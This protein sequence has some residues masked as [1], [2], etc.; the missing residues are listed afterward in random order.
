LFAPVVLDLDGDGVE[1]VSRKKSRASFDYG[2]DGA[3]DDTGWI[4]RDDGFLVID[5]NND[6]LIT[7]ASELSLASEDEDARSGLQGLARLDSNGDGVI[8]S[9]DA[10]FGELRVWQDRNG[11]GRTDAGEL[12]SLEEAGLVAIRLNA[13]TP[14]Q[15]Q[16]KLDRNVIAA[17]TTFVRAN[18]TTSTAADVS[19]AYRP[20]TGNTTSATS[21]ASSFDRFGSDLFLA[22]FRDTGFEREALLPTIDELVG[23]LG[24]ASSQ[25][26]S[27]LF[28]RYA[29]ES[30]VEPA[31]SQ[32][33]L[34]LPPV[35]ERASV[36]SQRAFDPVA[37]SLTMLQDYQQQFLPDVTIELQAND[38]LPIARVNE[39][40]EA[41]PVLDQ[42]VSSIAASE[43]LSAID[44][45]VVEA[46]PDG[47]PVGEVAAQPAT[48][49]LGSSVLLD[50][51]QF[52]V[53]GGPAR[54]AGLPQSPDQSVEVITPTAHVVRPGVDI[55]A[56][57]AQPDGDGTASNAE[58]ARKLAMIRQDMSSFGVAGAGELER[59]RQFEP[60]SSYLYA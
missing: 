7:E 4:G 22:P 14:S 37:G 5:R 45:N 34:T 23:L 48:P 36:L 51:A 43:S 44:P 52:V 54:I 2:G 58:V 42:R 28:D 41:D 20:V 60:Q 12:R 24:N 9:E 29:A 57:L 3:G 11:N 46:N 25:G 39:A 1:L 18:G 40:L 33:A 59:M 19:L 38:P 50:P 26:I 35:D 15:A 8:D 47:S 13:V 27:D 31:R 55:A 56:V 32:P 6:G 16:V 10:R 53:W 49:Q 30:A 17:T 21:L